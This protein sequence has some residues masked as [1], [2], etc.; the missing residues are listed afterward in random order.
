MNAEVFERQFAN[1]FTPD[2]PKDRKVVIV[3]DN[4]RY[5]S[6]LVEKISYLIKHRIE[7]PLPIPVK[8]KEETNYFKATILKKKN[9]FSAVTWK[10]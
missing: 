7:I 8:T 3:M 5:H 10:Q 2:L 1:R 9:K 6:R 4:A